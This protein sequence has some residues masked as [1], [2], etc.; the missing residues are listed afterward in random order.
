MFVFRGWAGHTLTMPCRFNGAQWGVLASVIPGEN[1]WI[2]PDVDP[3]RHPR[4]Y[5]SGCKS[6]FIICY[7]LFNLQTY[8]LLHTWSTCGSSI[9]TP[10]MSLISVW[11]PWLSLYE[12]HLFF[13]LNS[14]RGTLDVNDWLLKEVLKSIRK[15]F[16]GA[17]PAHIYLI[18][19]LIGSLDIW[20][21]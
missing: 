2:G 1:I 13:F 4:T 18:I 16:F 8:W 5:F 15:I 17:P 10:V 3:V 6:L 14:V 20:K 19:D 11:R 12:V 7:L 21:K 9:C